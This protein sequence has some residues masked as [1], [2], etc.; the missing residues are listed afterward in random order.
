V[1]ISVQIVAKH[2]Y[3]KIQAYEAD[4]SQWTIKS[5]ALEMGIQT[6]RVK[7]TRSLTLNPLLKLKEATGNSDFL[8]RAH[9]AVEGFTRGKVI[10]G[11]C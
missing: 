5:S 11:W 10:A 9:W 6:L 4:L 1:Y 2:S 8:L 3:A 7:L